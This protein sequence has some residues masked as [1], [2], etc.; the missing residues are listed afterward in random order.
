MKSLIFQFHTLI[1]QRHK[2]YEAALEANT[3]LVLEL[4]KEIPETESFVIQSLTKLAKQFKF[5][6]LVDLIEP[7]LSDD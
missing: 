4:V 6:K 5:E 2:F 3:Q 7:L 1:Q